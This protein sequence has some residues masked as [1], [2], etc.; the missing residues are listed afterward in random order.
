MGITEGTEKR[1][2]LFGKELV[3][4][5]RT[6]AYNNIRKKYAALARENELLVEDFYDKEIKSIEAYRKKVPIFC[7]ARMDDYINIGVVEL[8]ANGICN[9]DDV[10]LAEE[11]EK[12]WDSCWKAAFDN[13]DEKIGDVEIRQAERK[14][15]SQKA[16]EA[17]GNTVRTT[18]FFGNGSILQEMA[19]IGSAKV[20]DAV[21]NGAAKGI[22]KLVT[23]M[24]D[25]QADNQDE[26][27]KERIFKSPI[28]KIELVNGLKQDIFMLHK[29]VARLINENVSIKYYYASTDILAKNE[30]IVRNAL[31][32]NFVTEQP[33]TA[34]M[35]TRVRELLQANPYDLRL[36]GY[37]VKFKGGVTEEIRTMMNFFE[38]SISDLADAFLRSMYN[39]ADYPT[40][41]DSERLVHE[42]ERDL[43]GFGVTECYLLKEAKDHRDR[44]YEIRR[45][46]H[47]HI[48]NTIEERDAAEAEYK[49]FFAD[50]NLM[51]MN[52]DEIVDL[53]VE[54][55][56]ADLMPANAEYIRIELTDFADPLI[57][58]MKSIVD[59]NKAVD[60]IEF[61]AEK[62]G[63][64][65]SPIIEI[66]AKRRKTL[67]ARAKILAI[68]AAI[69]S[70]FVGIFLKIK[71]KIK[72]LRE[73]KTAAKQIKA[74]AAPAVQ[75]EPVAEVKAAPAPVVQ[76]E[77][78]AEVYAAPAPVVQPVP[79]AEVQATPAPVVQPESA[80]EAQATPAPAETKDCPQCGKKVKIN[81]KF[82]GKCGYRF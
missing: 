59:I 19:A 9:I 8:V 32:G 4:D 73:R 13:F 63:D 60:T 31:R 37:M 79:A 47:N 3:F 38:V 40:Y 75:P 54:T 65:V 70:W 52:I 42:I 28:N 44:L 51:E 55:M 43:K 61:Y 23:N 22:T 80:A 5:E 68:L 39:I 72:S 35:E 57:Y 58:R 12:D 49:A 1:F 46:Y 77:P 69:R 24:A 33:D 30:P 36:Y 14:L 62:H 25:K 50:K 26:R 67:E 2:N 29:T 41:E 10:I 45:T 48:F 17:A 71:L 21:I 76:P 18:G 56:K 16:I 74:E 6:V 27:E 82:C 53:Y 81:G 20:H 15:E 11:F 66:F 7:N 34:L 64:D 78:A